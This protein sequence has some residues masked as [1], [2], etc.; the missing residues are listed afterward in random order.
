MDSYTP[1]CTVGQHTARAHALSAIWFCI[2]F[3]LV[4]QFE[5]YRHTGH[6]FQTTEITMPTQGLPIR[7]LSHHTLQP[8]GALFRERLPQLWLS[9]SPL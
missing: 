6:L 2:M 8:A 7:P 1:G 5:K 9:A 4:V 3:L